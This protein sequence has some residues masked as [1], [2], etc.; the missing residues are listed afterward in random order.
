MIVSKERSRM[1]G[2]GTWW[3][4]LMGRLK[5]GATIE[6]ARVGLESLFQQS[7]VEHR[8]VRQLQQDNGG[9]ISNLSPKDYPRLFLDPGGQGEMVTQLRRI[10]LPAARCHGISIDDSLREYRESSIVAGL[11][12]TKRDCDAF[13]GGREP[14]TTYSSTA[15]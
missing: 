3:L 7:V 1:S 13:G 11:F 14:L 12:A 9:T 2:A 8:T 10:A 6:D 5:P 15:Y 4:R